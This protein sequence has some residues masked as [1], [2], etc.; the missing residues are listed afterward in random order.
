[1][2]FD[3]I[4]YRS[5]FDGAHRTLAAFTRDPVAAD[6]GCL[7]L[8]ENDLIALDAEKLSAALAACAQV[9][10]KIEFHFRHGEDGR[11]TDSLACR[12]NLLAALE[13]HFFIQNITSLSFAKPLDC[14]I[15]GKKPRGLQVPEP[16]TVMQPIFDRDAQEQGYFH[17]AEGFKA[18][19]LTTELDECRPYL[20]ARRHAVDIGARHGCFTRALLTEGFGKVTSFE[21]VAHF[22]EAFLKNV[23]T[24]KVDFY[25]LGLFD[26]ATLIDFEGRAG[27]GIKS[28]SGATG[29]PVHALDDFDLRDVDLIKIDVDG[30]DRQILRGARQTIERDRPV[31]HIETEE[32]QLRHDPEGLD[33]LED[34]YQWLVDDLDYAVGHKGRNTVLFPQDR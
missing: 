15:Y 25:N 31:V 21:L 28:M 2:Q 23:E 6:L 18:V 24:A 20:K 33:R 8:K 12:K 26:K 9:L 30:C 13:S 19:D 16:L 32:I 17:A 3:K 34:I 22:R 29:Q 10:V 27:K 11:L 4:Q 14:I 5:Y 7:C 1:M